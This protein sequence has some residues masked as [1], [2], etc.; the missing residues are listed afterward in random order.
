MFCFLGFAQN[1]HEFSIDSSKQAKPTEIARRLLKGKALGVNIAPTIGLILKPTVNS[2]Y[3]KKEEQ[4]RPLFVVDGFIY[5]NETENGL[6]YN[7]KNNS[8]SRF[9]DLDPKSIDSI[10]ILK[11][12]TAIDDYGEKG[13]NGVVLVTTKEPDLERIQEQKDLIEEQNRDNSNKKIINLS[14]LISDCEGIP[15]D[16]V[17]IKN[18][19]S[20]KN[21]KNSKNG[22]YWIILNKN[23]YLIFKKEGYYSQKIKIVNDKNIDII[24]KMIPVLPESQNPRDNIIIRKPIIYLYPTEKTEIN[25]QIDFKGKLLT[26]FPKYENG[27]NV[28]AYPNGKILDKKSNRFYTSLFWDGEINFPQ[29]H[30]DYKSGFEVSKNN[31]NAF[32]IEK[33]EYLGLNTFETNDFIQYWLPILE[34]NEINFIH[35]LVNEDYDSISKNII[36]PNPNTQIRIFMEFYKLENKTNLPEQKLLKYI[37]NGFTLVEWGGSDVSSEMKLKL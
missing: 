12:Q 3:Q 8:N 2:N 35:F 27:W 17:E 21:Y 33:L 20:K 9:L 16:D 14:G 1:N 32:L 36:N 4:P 22:Q 13:K 6:F 11:G 37:R 23:D 30:Y 26:T 5:D 25:L 29:E 24:L 15:I 28:T 18:L 7:D 34:K 19:N 10:D 31:L